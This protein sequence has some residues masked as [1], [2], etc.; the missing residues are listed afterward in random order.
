VSK[1]PPCRLRHGPL[2]LVED[3][4]SIFRDHPRRWLSLWIAT[5]ALLTLGP[6][7]PSGPSTPF[8]CFPCGNWGTADAILNVALFVPAGVLL[9]WAGTSVLVVAV[10][11][12]GSSMGIEAVQTL[13][14]GRYPTAVDILANGVGAL[15]G[16][17]WVRRGADRLESPHLIAALSA[18]TLLLTAWQAWPAPPSGQL[19]GQHNPE[20]GGVPAYQGTV[21]EARIGELRVPSRQV[22]DSEALR[23]ALGADARGSVVFEIAPPVDVWTPVFAIFSAEQEEALFVA[24]RGS[25]LLVRSRTVAGALRLRAP[26]AVVRG[27]LAVP[28][29]ESPLAVTFRDSEAGR[30]IGLGGVEGCGYG[31]RPQEGWRFLL[32]G[33]TWPP[34]SRSLMSVF[35]V[36]VPFGLLFRAEGTTRERGVLAVGLLALTLAL[37]GFSPL[38]PGGYSSLAVGVLC[39]TLFGFNPRSRRFWLPSDDGTIF[40][41]G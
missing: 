19:F 13:L 22:D 39:G 33:D 37:P 29:D 25:D 9:G 11:G 17:W 40:E 7:D 35:W 12:F 23:A 14:P 36:A 18:V 34:W 16:L 28:V 3:P 8:L 2:D 4:L 1:E 38:V 24:V 6:G 21:V 31:V 41:T 10:L 15:V 5:V 27:V 20:L 30:C 32:G 26:G